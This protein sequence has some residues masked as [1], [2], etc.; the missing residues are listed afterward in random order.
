MHFSIL[1]PLSAQADDG[2]ELDLARRSQRGTLAV[3]LLYHG[4][5][6]ARTQLIDALWGDD[7]PT[8]ADRALRVR[9]SDLRRVLAGC[10]RLV[11]HPAGYQLVTEPGELDLAVFQK[12]AHDGRVALDTGRFADADD[13]LARACAL[14]RSPPLADLPDTPIMEL[15]RAALVAQRRDAQEWLIDARLA[16]GRHHETLAQIRG[17]I[18]A[19]PLAERSHVQLMLALDRCG[20]KSAALAAYGTL[21]E[22]T[23]R[24]FGQDPGPE[25]RALLSQLLAD[26]PGVLQSAASR[27]GRRQLLLRTGIWSDGQDQRDPQA[28][29]AGR[30]R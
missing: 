8:G 28:V 6:P 26:S 3:L 11:T 30:T 21:R 12:L 5:R 1:G 22:L 13:M 17:C 24:E 16:L 29:R 20:Q 23:M 2:T 14:W 18:A 7:P 4:Q 15:T 25:A 19:D 10:R 27:D 9:M